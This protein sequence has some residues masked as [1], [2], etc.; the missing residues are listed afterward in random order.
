MKT[1]SVN[2][3]INKSILVRNLL[4]HRQ[5]EE[6]G[7]EFSKA[8]INAV[9][10]KGAALIL[11]L[12][13]YSSERLMEDIDMLVRPKDLAAAREALARLGYLPLPEDPCA[14]S[15]PSKTAPVDLTDNLWYLDKAEN[16]EV[17]SEALRHRFKGSAAAFCHLRPEDFYIHVLA[18]GALQHAEDSGIWKKDLSLIWAHW[19]KTI[20]WAEV[21]AKLKQYGFQE[22]VDTYMAPETAD[23]SFY[24][25]LLNMKD[26]PFKG[27]IARFIFLPAG[28]KLGYIRSS[29]FPGAEFLKNRY[30]LKNEAEIFY[31]KLLRPF[32]FIS[33]LARFAARAI[34]NGKFQ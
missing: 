14:V 9:L 27:H 21:E 15:N 11:L 2:R 5:L 17:F 22:A 31:Y 8:S 26:N 33:N 18:H 32:L 16:E 20:K 28:K 7:R 10:L 4:I 34:L 24:L 29:L 19:G 6:I 1:I 3:S 13:D 30:N 25:R 23:D 12:P